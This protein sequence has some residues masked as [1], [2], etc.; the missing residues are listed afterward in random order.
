MDA[1][2]SVMTPNQNVMTSIQSR[3]TPGHYGMTY[4][5]NEMTRRHNVIPPSHYKMILNRY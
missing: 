5:P 1:Y 3:K 2:E 4:S